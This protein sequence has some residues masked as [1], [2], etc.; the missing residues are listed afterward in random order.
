MT[1]TETK[2]VMTCPICG[3]EIDVDKYMIMDRLSSWGYMHIDVWVKCPKC[4]YTPCFGKELEDTKPIYWQPS[5]L[6][7]WYKKA[8]EKAFDKNVTCDPCLFCE[9]KMELHKVWIN[10]YRELCDGAT[11][12]VVPDGVEKIVKYFL[13]SGILSQFKCVNHKCKYVR[14]IT[15]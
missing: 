7:A 11:Q 14:Y 4:K 3:T 12:F 6:P 15:L 8:V 1:E 13:P 9:G 5:S 2:T 10:S